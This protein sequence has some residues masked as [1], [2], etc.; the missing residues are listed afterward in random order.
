MAEDIGPRECTRCHQVKPLN[1][2]RAKVGNRVVKPCLSCRDQDQG[3]TARKRRSFEAQLTSPDRPRRSGL[4]ADES[5]SSFKRP[6]A[7]RILFPEHDMRPTAQDDDQLFLRLLDLQSRAAVYRIVTV[8]STPRIHQPKQRLVGGG[9]RIKGH[10]VLQD[11]GEQPDPTQDLEARAAS[12]D[13]LAGV[14]SQLSAGDMPFWKSVDARAA[15]RF[16]TPR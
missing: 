9:N 3:R 16:S 7:S 15:S 6:T 8:E 1:Q 2:F 10:I 5:V 14:G 4:Q 12:S 11:A 13:T